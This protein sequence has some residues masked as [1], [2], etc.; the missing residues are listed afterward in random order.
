MKRLLHCTLAAAGLE[1]D[2]ILV[3][4]H[5]ADHTGGVAALAMWIGLSLLALTLDRR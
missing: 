1:L 2:T 5:H 3:T 4:H